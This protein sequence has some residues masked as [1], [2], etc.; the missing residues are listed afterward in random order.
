MLS[1]CRQ[2]LARKPEDVQAPLQG[3]VLD[4]MRQFALEQTYGK[5]DQ[6]ELGYVVFYL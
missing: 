5:P 1:I 3:L 2:K 6:P 4:D